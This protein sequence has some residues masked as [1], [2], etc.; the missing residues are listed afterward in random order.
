MRTS[1]YASVMQLFQTLNLLILMHSLLSDQDIH[2]CR[3][4]MLV[5]PDN[6]YNSSIIP[7]KNLKNKCFKLFFSFLNFNFK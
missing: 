7:E 6:F 1:K 3:Q 4:I 2:S 5:L